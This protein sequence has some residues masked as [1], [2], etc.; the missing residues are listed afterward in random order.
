V[1]QIAR[2]L[3][4]LHEHFVIHGALRG[5]NILVDD[6]GHARICDYGL[7]SII[8]PSEFTSIR[9]CR[10]AAPEI[11]SPA[12]DVQNANTCNFLP[13]FTKE[14]DIYA[15]GMTILEIFTENIPFS[16][17]K[18]DS[19]LIFHVLNGGRPEL[20]SFLLTQE[21]LP[22]LIEECWDPEPDSRPIARVLRERLITRTLKGGTGDDTLNKVALGVFPTVFPDT[23]GGVDAK[24]GTYSAVGRDQYF[25]VNH[26]NNY[27]DNASYIHPWHFCVALLL[28]LFV[29]PLLTLGCSPVA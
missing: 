7:T 22:K 16:H 2:G 10:W 24:N 4:Y 13:L 20:P 19:S 25:V 23:Q 15:F 17:M 11:M 14:S 3:E 29:V 12:E 18:N 8:E 26:V 5:A 27:V 1:R 9:T 6:D 21:G 28:F